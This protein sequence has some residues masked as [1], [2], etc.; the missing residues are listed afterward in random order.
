MLL[1]DE[2]AAQRNH[3]QHA[4]PSA[5]QRQEKDAPVLQRK[6]QKDQRGQRE[7]HAAGNGF[8]GRAGGLHDIVFEDADLAEGAQDADGKHGDGNRRRDGEPGAQAHVHGDRAEEESGEDAQQDGAQGEFRQE[9]FPRRRKGGTRRA[10]PSNSMAWSPD[11]TSAG[12]PREFA[13]RRTLGK[14]RCR[15]TT[16]A[17]AISQQAPIMAVAKSLSQQLSPPESAV[18]ATRRGRSR[19]GGPWS[20]ARRRAPAGAPR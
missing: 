16:V 20:R 6:A 8:A 4:Q 3:E 15:D 13:P 17:A 7:N 18:D 2:L 19:R 14:V 9:S 10:A 5:D 12:L 1:D 11:V